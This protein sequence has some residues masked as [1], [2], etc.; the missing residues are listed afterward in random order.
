MA[1]T[2]EELQAFIDEV[3]AVCDKHGV[4][5][6]GTS[7][8]ESAP[9]E[10]TIVEKDI[11]S[12]WHIDD[13]T[14]SNVVVEAKPAADKWS[15]P[16]AAWVSGIGTWP[17]QDPKPM[18]LEGYR[19]FPLGLSVKEL[20]ELVKDWPELDRVGEPNTVW[21]EHDNG[22]SSPIKMFAPLNLRTLD[23]G[24]KTA[25]IILSKDLD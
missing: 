5:L 15:E 22:L 18:Q 4:C 16:Q 21:V 25:D 24:T 6:I 17:M 13:G 14:V 9:G 19:H 20:K 3:K 1:K 10:I 7:I 8:D 2:K 12:G 23:D 11:N